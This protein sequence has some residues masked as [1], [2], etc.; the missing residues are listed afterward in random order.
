M[1]TTAKRVWKVAC[2]SRIGP[3]VMLSILGSLIQESRPWD[4]G[5]DGLS[6]MA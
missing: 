3:L 5:S 6:W 2:A 4:R 1:T